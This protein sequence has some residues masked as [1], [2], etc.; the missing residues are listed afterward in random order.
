MAGA[1]APRIGG[2]SEVREGLVEQ[3]LR[4]LESWT[5]HGEPDGVRMRR[6]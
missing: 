5:G 1:K 4:A 3:V 2:D 6:V